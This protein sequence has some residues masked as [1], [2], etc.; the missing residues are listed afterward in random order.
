MNRVGIIGGGIVGLSSAYFL[1]Q[2]GF[3][4]TIIEQGDLQDGC[5]FNN[6]GMIVPS[7]IIPLAAP[8][9][10]AKG[11]RWMFDATSPF[12]V[13]PRFNKDLIRW[14]WQFYKHA[15]AAHVARAIPALKA[16]SLFSKSVYQQWAKDLPFDFGYHER[17]LMMLYQSPEAE[18]EEAETAHMANKA[19]VEA[20]ILSLAEIQKM[21]PDVLVKA[22]G[23]VYYPG[24]AHLTPAI[25]VREL[26]ELLKKSGVVFCTNTRVTGVVTE[27]NQV[28]VVHTNQ[29][30]IEMDQWVLASGSWS[31]TL[32]ES[33]G[34]SLPMQAGKG[35]SFTL[36]QVEKNT[37]IPSI[38]LEARVA[39][40]PMG[41]SL[42]FGGTMEIAGVNHDINM[43]RVKGIVDSI[44]RYY[45]EMK[46]GMPAVNKVW[47]GL[48]PCSPDGL[49]YIGRSN[50]RPNVIVATGHAMMGLSLAP[51][52]GK[53][54]AEIAAHGR[55]SIDLD[56]FGPER[57]PA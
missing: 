1:R 40:T 29:G 53:L 18:H 49:P 2:A 54:V 34:I 20:Q 28:K 9:M 11:I 30:E 57:Y 3:E 31:G 17:G 45:P 14:G 13:R 21:E 55:P 26:I 7:H 43:N 52:T 5:S 27:R 44:P 22:R 41:S 24:D 48:R 8:G 38:F 50:A 16:L 19:G 42:R 12:Y 15:N 33:F 23:G 56:A 35:Y 46:V 36:D 6:A 37:R 47:H 51:G 32:A 4:V 39:V 25:L 10:I